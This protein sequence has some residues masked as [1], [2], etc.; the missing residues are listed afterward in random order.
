MSTK[1]SEVTGV[2]MVGETMFV[3]G[4]EVQAVPVRTELEEFL[5]FLKKCQQNSP[6]LLVGHNI[7]FFDSNILIHALRNCD[8][9]SDFEKETA[10][11]LDALKKT[12]P[13]QPSYK[14]EDL[15]KNILGH[16]KLI[17]SSTDFLQ[18]KNGASERK[19]N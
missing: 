19:K 16:T 12:F 18:K 17:I 15:L 7:K 3:H 10:G 8:F 14:Q 2:T 6:V 11:F 5:A 4:K 9:L 13:K 1:A